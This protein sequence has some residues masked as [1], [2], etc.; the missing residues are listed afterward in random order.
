VVHHVHKPVGINHT[1]AMMTIA[2][3][4][5]TVQKVNISMTASAWTDMN[6]H[7]SLAVTN[8][9]QDQESDVIVTNVSVSMVDGCAPRTNVM[10]SAQL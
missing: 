4:A 9:N 7:V 10:V 8:T 3:M 6:V 5:V 2:L 1:T